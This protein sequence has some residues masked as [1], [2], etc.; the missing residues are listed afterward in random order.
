MAS[1]SQPYGHLQP[2]QATT[3]SVSACKHQAQ[4]SCD[5]CKLAQDMADRVRG[6]ITPIPMSELVKSA[7]PD[8]RPM[9]SFMLFRKCVTHYLKQRHQVGNS[10][11]GKVIT[12]IASKLW[13]QLARERKDVYA[14]LATELQEG[15]QKNERKISYRL[16]RG[17][18]AWRFNTPDSVR[19]ATKK[20]RTKRATK[21]NPNNKDNNNAG[22]PD[23]AVDKNISA[24]NNNQ[25]PN[26]ASSFSMPLDPF[27]TEDT[28]FAENAQLPYA[29]TVGL[30]VAQ[31]LDG[32]VNGL[33]DEWQQPFQLFS[34]EYWQPGM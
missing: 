19:N 25:Y 27:L 10:V 15:T 30:Q 16:K 33:P 6:L 3:I 21:R 22:I 13:N 26:E 2:N 5:E 31:G 34:F 32:F 1:V 11:N 29:Q 24:T 17:S 18:Q 4:T 20:K 23:K 14:K 28:V 12:L 9:N 8:K 7:S